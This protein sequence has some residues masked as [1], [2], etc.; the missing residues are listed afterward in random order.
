MDH[1]AGRR[2]PAKRHKAA[3]RQNVTAV[4]V[5]VLQGIP[6]HARRQHRDADDLVRRVS[7]RRR[8]GAGHH[9]QSSLA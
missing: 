4:V 1:F 8:S 7:I 9:Q 3:A 5:R 6:S 2:R